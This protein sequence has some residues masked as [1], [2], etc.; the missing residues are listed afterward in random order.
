MVINSTLGFSKLAPISQV[1]AKG[2]PIAVTLDI[3]PALAPMRAA[4]VHSAQIV[5]PTMNVLDHPKRAM[6]LVNKFAAPF[7]ATLLSLVTSLP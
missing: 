4:V 5:L 6:R 7:V 3:S 2:K 1:S